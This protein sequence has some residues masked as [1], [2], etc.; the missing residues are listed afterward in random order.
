MK[1]LYIDFELNSRREIIEFGAVLINNGKIACEL[2][3]FVQRLPEDS[4]FHY[5][6][7]AEN[8]H[9]IL[10]GTLKELGCNVQ[11]MEKEFFELILE[12]TAA[13]SVFYI[14]GHGE[15]TKQIYL[16][17]V[18]PF[19]RDFN[20][21]NYEQVELPPWVERE[22]A[23]YHISAYK[24]KQQCRIVSCNKDYHSITYYPHWKR[25]NKQASHTQMAK[26]SYGFHCALIDAYELAF[27]DGAIDPYCCD[28]HFKRLYL[29]I[30]EPIS[31]S[32]CNS[33]A[34]NLTDDDDELPYY[35]KL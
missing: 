8:S 34:Y 27:K 25:L 2:H 33:I 18:F 11:T 21:I 22:P 17:R 10:P 19:L 4:K 7:T 24:M 30:D 15:D 32:S 31:Y 29:N 35:N 20:N 12:E 23:F 14:K 3:K 26:E 5:Y 13:E 1:T 9:C 28:L 6:R 16:E